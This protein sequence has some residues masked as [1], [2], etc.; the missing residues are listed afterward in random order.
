MSDIKITVAV[1]GEQVTARLTGHRLGEQLSTSHI[2]RIHDVLD[3]A[4]AVLRIPEPR[5]Q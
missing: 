1:G 2:D 4:L 3:R 5:E